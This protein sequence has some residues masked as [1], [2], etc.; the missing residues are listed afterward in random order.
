MEAIDQLCNLENKLEFMF[1]STYS[2]MYM[3]ADENGEITKSDVSGFWLIFDELK[4]DI[5][6]LKKELNNG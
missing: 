6:Q 4:T 1:N 2:L 3:C 5:Q